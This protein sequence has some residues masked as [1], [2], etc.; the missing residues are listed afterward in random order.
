[1]PIEIRMPRPAPDIDEADLIAWLVEPGA[2][3]ALGDPILEIET[4]KST[5]EIE[6]PCAG[7]LLEIL[8]PPG[9]LGVP[10]DTLLGLIEPSQTDTEPAPD[11]SADPA[12]STLTPAAPP[13]PATEPAPPS[14][15][16]ARRLAKRAGI[17]LGSIQ[18]SGFHGRV[19]REDVERSPLSPNAPAGTFSPSLRLEADCQVD[20]LMEILAHLEQDPGGSAIPLEVALL[21]ATALGI[22][23]TPEIRRNPVGAGDATEPAPVDIALS[24]HP[25][26]EEPRGLRGVDRKGF[27]ALS[28]EWTATGS[29]E[30]ADMHPENGPPEFALAHMGLEGVDRYW[31]P[32]EPGTLVSVGTALP[33]PQPVLRGEA[34][35]AGYVL[36]LTLCADAR[37]IDPPGAARLLARIRR[38]IEQPLEMAL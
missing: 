11:R 20:A 4:E 6:S 21:R 27:A 32:V 17:A 38:L 29:A 30:Q 12:A 24:T 15:A 36:S 34:V 37:A 31:P 5:L 18:G 8:V 1:M 2:E 14:T 35:G 33:R 23:E 9:S 19:T 3:I 13:P 28:A 25:A 26:A 7:Q 22:R 10:V 16:L